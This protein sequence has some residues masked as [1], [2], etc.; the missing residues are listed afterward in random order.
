MSTKTNCQQFQ[1]NSQ[2]T[3]WSRRQ[4][5]AFSMGLSNLVKLN[6]HLPISS[7]RTTVCIHRNSTTHHLILLQS[8]TALQQIATPI[9]L[10]L[11]RNNPS[12]IGLNLPQQ[13]YQRQ[14]Q[15]QYLERYLERYQ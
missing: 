8:T 15:Q 9:Q 4:R 6:H 2:D 7:P 14:Y 11:P 13:Q 5:V 3:K 10:T 1:K 12:S